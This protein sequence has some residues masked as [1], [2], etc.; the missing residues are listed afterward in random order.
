MNVKGHSK[1]IETRYI[2]CTCITNITNK[3]SMFFQK[4]SIIINLKHEN[5]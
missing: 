3:S 2:N 4:G 5:Q 1:N